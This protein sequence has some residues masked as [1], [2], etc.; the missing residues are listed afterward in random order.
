M[1]LEGYVSP[2]EQRLQKKQK[3]LKNTGKWASVAGTSLSWIPFVGPFLALAG[4]GIKAGT[5]IAAGKAQK[6][7]ALV[8]EQRA[9]QLQADPISS[10]YRK[11]QQAAELAQ[12]SG[13][14][15][16]E[17]YRRNIE[18][19]QAQAL[20][21]AMQSAT[22]GEQA[23]V[24]A[25]NIA[26]QS[27]AEQAKLAAQDA[28]QRIMLGQESR[29]ALQT[30]GDQETASEIRKIAERDK[31]RRAG[32]AFANAGTGNI[33]QGIS[34]IAD[35]TAQLGR[36]IYNTA[37]TAK[38][39]KVANQDSEMSD[40]DA[41]QLR[42]DVNMANYE[43]EQYAKERGELNSAIDSSKFDPQEE[44]MLV[45][46]AET[47]TFEQKQ[48]MSSK[49]GELRKDPVKNRAEIMMLQDAIDANAKTQ[50]IS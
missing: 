20:N 15:G 33:M 22:G 28:Q 45:T 11:A 48:K 16:Y 17:Q 26:S 30:I 37:Q 8:K 3:D 9:A 10:A 21:Q 2:E 14:G 35:T 13:L 38:A 19:N 4:A 7:E 12:I 42:S 50:A 44:W 39:N 6:R 25:S 31:L 36:T 18:Q 43:R 47:L 46:P 29:R 24:A 40:L 23:L 5:D 32:A 41:T 34:G 27:N 1:A 49:L